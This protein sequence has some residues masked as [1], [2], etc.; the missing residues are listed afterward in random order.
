CKQ[1]GEG[2]T[3]AVEALEQR[4]LTGLSGGK[5]GGESST[6]LLKSG[7]RLGQLGFADGEGRLLCACGRGPRGGDEG[8][9][10]PGQVV[11]QR[12]AAIRVLAA[13]ALE[14]RLEGNTRSQG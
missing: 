2:T 7:H 11:D 13:V 10:A 8:I 14:R 9:G 5:V 12:S 1:L 6:P 4:A 3:G